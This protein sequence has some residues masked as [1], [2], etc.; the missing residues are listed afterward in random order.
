MNWMLLGGVWVRTNF[1]AIGTQRREQLKPDRLGPPTLG[2][3]YIGVLDKFWK[4][5][6]EGGNGGDGLSAL[7]GELSF[8]VL[9]VIQAD[10]SSSSWWYLRLGQERCLG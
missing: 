10:P 6:L 5:C 4:R 2:N 3:G 9:W 7:M 1:G 8:R